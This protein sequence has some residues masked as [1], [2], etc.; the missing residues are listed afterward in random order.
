MILIR[1]ARSVS[2]T[3]LDSYQLQ[4]WLHERNEPADHGAGMYAYLKPPSCPQQGLPLQVYHP[5]IFEPGS[6]QAC[7]TPSLCRNHCRLSLPFPPS[8]HQLL[9]KLAH[10][11]T[12][13]LEV[14]GP[15]L[16][17]APCRATACRRQEAGYMWTAAHSQEEC[18]QGLRLRLP[19]KRYP[20][21]FA[22]QV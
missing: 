20:C 13:P 21:R 16:T 9:Q 12:K 11:L 2:H 19:A 7:G 18:R 3:D 17:T 1:T 15:R 22:D 6:S 4:H 8:P 5:F 10:S 14:R